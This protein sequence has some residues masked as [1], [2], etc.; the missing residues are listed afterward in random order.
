MH[1][2]NPDATPALSHESWL[3]EKSDSGWKFGPVK[4]AEKKEHPCMVPFEALPPEQQM[5]DILFAAIVRAL[6]Q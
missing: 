6:G 2:D 4:D 1:L 5:K 3:K